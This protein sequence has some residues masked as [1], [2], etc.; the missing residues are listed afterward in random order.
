MFQSDV[1]VL[2]LFSYE[3]VWSQVLR[4]CSLPN[5]GPYRIHKRPVLLPQFSLQKLPY[6]VPR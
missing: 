1:K 5:Q 2:T 4:M 3:F 6:K